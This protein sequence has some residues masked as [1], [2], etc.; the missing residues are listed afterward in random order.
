MAIRIGITGTYLFGSTTRRNFISLPLIALSA[1][2]LKPRQQNNLWNYYL[3]T[4]D[5]HLRPATVQFIQF[6]LS[7]QPCRECNYHAQI[8]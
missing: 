2:T 7:A 1:T 5:N 6:H 8:N 4:A 3:R